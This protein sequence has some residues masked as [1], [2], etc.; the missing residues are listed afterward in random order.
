M[1][2]H[3]HPISIVV[4]DDHFIFRQGIINTLLSL[5]FIKILGQAANGH[6]LVSLVEQTSPDLA[7]T[8]VQMPVM[9]GYEATAAIAQHYSKTRVLALSYNQDPVSV[10]RMLEAGASGYLQKSAEVGQISLAINTILQNENV[11]FTCNGTVLK[12]LVRPQNAAADAGITAKERKV[13]DLLCRQFTNQEIAS[14]IGCSNRAVE[15]AKERLQIKTG[16]RS[17]LGIALYAIKHGLFFL[18]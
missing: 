17:R 12:H 5:P 11:F 6:E 4:A 16:S 18:D 14:E 13:M 10:R 1:L 7:I 8:D 2:H 9:N 3:L 15:S